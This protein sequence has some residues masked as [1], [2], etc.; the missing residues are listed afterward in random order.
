MPN[1]AQEILDLELQLKSIREEILGDWKDEKC[2]KDLEKTVL[3]TKE[4]LV[5]TF[6]KSL[7]R[8]SQFKPE[9]CTVKKVVKKF[10]D[11]LK[12]ENKKKRLPIQSCVVDF[13]RA[14][15]YIPMLAREGVKHDV[16]YEEGRGGLLVREPSSRSQT[17]QLLV[18]GYKAAE[19]KDDDEN[20]VK[21]L[22]VLHNDGL[23]KKEDLA[24]WGLIRFC[25][26]KWSQK[27]FKY[28]LSL[29]PH[30]LEDYEAF[31]DTLMHLVLS[32]YV[33]I[34]HIKAL[35]TTTMELFPEQVGYLFQKDVE[36]EMT[37]VERAIEVYGEKETMEVLHDILSPSSQFPI[38][39][40]AL[41]HA[42]KLDKIFMKWFPWAY[43]LRDDHGRSLVQ[44]ILA[45]GAGAVRENSHI[46][47]S[48]SDDQIRTKD[49]V[50]TLYPFAAVAS[51]EEGD[52]EKAFYLLRR[53]PCVL[54]TLASTFGVGVSKKRKR[55][56]EDA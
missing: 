48:M 34:E 41:V 55:V 20:I 18:R 17:L 49:P 52:L 39:H 25:T 24:G 28:L 16:G 6:G 21:V 27:R 30:I 38:L 5:E 53:Q 10:P 13:R 8:L 46:F 54:E 31:E 51:G 45:A 26:W 14:E 11:S 7:H 9:E 19:T 23:L 42:P 37:V 32:P 40:H 56:D 33:K 15:K 22:Q 47:A 3:S 29:D 44:C 36:M 2:W 4:K 35:W 50:T 43:N 1:L 12:V